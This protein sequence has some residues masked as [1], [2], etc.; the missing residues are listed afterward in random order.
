MGV[1]DTFGPTPVGVFFGEPG[2]EVDDP[3][4]GGVGPGAHGLHRV[5]RVHDRLPPRRQEHACC[6]NYLYLA[7]RGGAEVHPL[8]TVTTIRP[9]ARRALRRRHRAHRRVGPQAAPH[10]RRP[11]RGVGGR[12]ARHAEAAA[13][14]ARRG[15]PPAPVRRASASSPART[16]RRSSAPAPSGKDVD[17]TRGVAITSS[18]HPDD[19]THIEPV[20]Y[21]KGS[22]VMGLLTTALADGGGRSRPLTWLERGGPPPGDARCAT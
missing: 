21:G 8:T 2:V 12:H 6:K 20:R 14:H 9:L 16:P 13:P 7:E 1:G 17:F 3:F 19:H 10:V 18:F 5:R 22:N 15:P 4:F 11:R